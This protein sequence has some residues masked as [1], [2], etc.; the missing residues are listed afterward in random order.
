[1]NLNK[2]ERQYIIQEFLDV[3]SCNQIGGEEVT[4]DNYK[5]FTVDDFTYIKT[6]DFKII[7]SIIDKLKDVTK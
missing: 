6:K 4:L 1:M 5:K 7:I 2:K 3:L